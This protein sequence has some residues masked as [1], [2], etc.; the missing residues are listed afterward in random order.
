MVENM[1]VSFHVPIMIGLCKTVGSLF[2]ACDF[3]TFRL[4]CRGCATGGPSS[5]LCL[6]S[7]IKPPISHNQGPKHVAL[8]SPIN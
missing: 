7:E 8:W 3:S 2:C 1:S 4:G 5:I 6:F